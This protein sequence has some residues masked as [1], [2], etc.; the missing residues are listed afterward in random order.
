MLK[1]IPINYISAFVIF[2]VVILWI[3]SGS[4]KNDNSEETVT[5]ET[6]V[7]ELISVRAKKLFITK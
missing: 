2:I 5:T 1:K 3:F 7:E 6:N 4:F